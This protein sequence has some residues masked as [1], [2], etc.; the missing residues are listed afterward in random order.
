[1]A[2]I[3]VRE[4]GY[5]G[6][7]VD[8]NPLELSPQELRQAQ[9]AIAPLKTGAGIRKRPGLQPFL[10]ED[11]DLGSGM[12]VEDQAALGGVAL[13]FGQAWTTY[14]RLFLGRGGA[15]S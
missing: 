8:K 9:N 15:S 6:V 1:M 13:P 5:S 11:N 14:G 10:V 7:N 3:K 4:M 12:Y 2:D